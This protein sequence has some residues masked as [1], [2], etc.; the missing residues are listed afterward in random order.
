MYTGCIPNISFLGVLEVIGKFAVVGWW[1]DILTGQLYCHSKLKWVELCCD[2]FLLKD[3]DKPLAVIS[4]VNSAV[5]ADVSQI[6]SNNLTKV[7]INKN[8]RERS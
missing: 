3:S 2:N 8:R 6:I 7:K 1:V 5:K 4:L